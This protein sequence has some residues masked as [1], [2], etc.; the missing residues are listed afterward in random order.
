MFF[1]R[2]I[3]HEDKKF[4]RTPLYRST[5][6]LQGAELNYP[7]L[8]KLILAL[9]HA[10][11]RLGRYFQAH[12]ITVPT[13]EHDIIFLKRDE[14]ETPADYL[15]EIPFNDNEKKVKEKEVSD[16]SN[17]W[18]LYTDRASS[19]DGA[20]TG[21]MLIDPTG[22]KYTY[23]LRFEFETTNNEAE[24]EALLAGLRIA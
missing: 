18:K 16:P 20:G 5:T 19:S 10:A 12:T 13:G 17:K 24:Y 21:L 3:R 14:R 11:R 6:H 1:R 7:A 4:G 9:V 22:K 8:K 2:S 23:A 15:P